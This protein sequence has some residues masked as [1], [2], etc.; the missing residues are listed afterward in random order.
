MIVTTQ[1][2]IDLARL[3][4]DA[5]DRNAIDSMIPVVERFIINY[6]KNHFIVDDV[7]I[8][9]STIAFVAGSPATITDSDSGFV[10]AKFYDE[11]DISVRNSYNNNGLYRVSTVAA[12]TLT[13]HD[14]ESLT[15]E[16]ATTPYVTIFAVEFP[17]DVKMMAAKMVFHNMLTMNDFAEVGFGENSGYPAE[18]L[19]ELQYYRKLTLA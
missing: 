14:S 2:V 17:E 10:T 9:A 5:T 12:G 11:M 18:I 19:K 16:A 8:Y 3:S 4:S 13:L 15:T 1:E 6:T 7:Y